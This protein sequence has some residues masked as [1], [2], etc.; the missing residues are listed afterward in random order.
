MRILRNTL[1]LS[2]LLFIFNLQAVMHAKE[3]MTRD[4]VCEF[5]MEKEDDPESERITPDKIEDAKKMVPSLIDYMQNGEDGFC[6]S[7]A[8]DVLGRTR[9]KRASEPLLAELYKKQ[10]SQRI[11]PIAALGNLGDPRALDPLISE[12]QRD[13]TPHDQISMVVA[14]A[15]GGIRNARAI[16]PLIKLLQTDKDPAA[17]YEAATALGK[18]KDKRAVQPLIAALQSDP[19]ENVKGY[20]AGALGEIE[21]ARA[22]EALIIALGQEK[23]SSSKFILI[24]QA[25]AKKHETR[26]RNALIEKYRNLKDSSAKSYLFATMK[27]AGISVDGK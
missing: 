5:L 11:S 8:M 7:L 21:D 6:A 2:C 23:T 4:E 18:I 17:R 1:I 10:G 14:Q 27:Q 13:R 3:K 20:A 26:A 24:T 25:L 16:D 12:L 22:T 9:D 15:L 19:D